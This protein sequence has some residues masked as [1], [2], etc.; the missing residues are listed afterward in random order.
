MA[1]PKRI[2][3]CPI[4]EAIVELRFQSQILPE[5]VFGIIY[6]AL[7]PKFAKLE[8]LPILQIPEVIRLNDPQ[9]AY[10]PYYKFIS[11]TFTFQ[12]GAKVLS[13]SNPGNYV[14]WDK[15]SSQL[16][17]TFKEIQKLNF[18]KQV[19]RLG[20]RY[21]NFFENINI[22]ENITLSV[23][24][25]GVPLDSERLLTRAELKRGN[26]LGVLQIAGNTNLALINKPPK[27]GSVIDIDIV[28]EIKDDF[29]K[30]MDVLLKEG[31]EE[32]KK[33]FYGLLKEDFLLKYNPE[34]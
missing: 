7:I 28:R 19:E 4:V 18:I 32:E 5:A 3:P 9:L 12:L 26:F 16:I 13:L 2:T 23:E 6:N 17:E 20:I 15:F 10:Q 33:L 11:D 24:M 27:K 21:I 31:H 30:G 14:G 8:K 34:Y 22:Y 29:F 25:N 1:L